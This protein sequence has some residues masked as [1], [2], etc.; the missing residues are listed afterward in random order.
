MFQLVTTLLCLYNLYKEVSAFYLRFRPVIDLFRSFWFVSVILLALFR[1]FN[2][3]IKMGEGIFPPIFVCFNPCMHACKVCG[4][5]A[6]IVNLSLVYE[7]LMPT[8]LSEWAVYRLASLISCR[9]KQKRL[10][11]NDFQ[12]HHFSVEMSNAKTKEILLSF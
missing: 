10:R 8:K 5:Y 9:Q 11:S 12:E 4:C 6:L 2:I 7:T 1:E 3:K